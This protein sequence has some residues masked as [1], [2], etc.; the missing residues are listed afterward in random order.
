M[1]TLINKQ[2]KV[3]TGEE[4]AKESFHAQ[5]ESQKD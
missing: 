5:D 1:A 3:V 2:Y 4:T